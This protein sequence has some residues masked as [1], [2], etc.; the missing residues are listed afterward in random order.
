VTIHNVT[1]KKYIGSA[2]LNPDLVGGQ[3]AAF[4]PGMPKAV[5][6]SFSIGKLR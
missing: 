4:E 6:L 5:T 2:F 1:D 3:P